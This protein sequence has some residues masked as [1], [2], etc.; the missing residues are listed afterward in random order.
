[1]ARLAILLL[2]N[3]TETLESNETQVMKSAQIS[4]Q[5]GTCKV[6]TF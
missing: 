6:T 3:K 5:V 1:M 2:S 4:E